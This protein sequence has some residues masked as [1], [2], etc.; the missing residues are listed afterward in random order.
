MIVSLLKRENRNR[1]AFVEPPHLASTHTSCI[2]C[3]VVW[4]VHTL[5][6]DSHRIIRPSL[7]STTTAAC[8]SSR[9]NRNQTQPKHTQFNYFEFIDAVDCNTLQCCFGES[10]DDAGEMLPTHWSQLISNVFSCTWI[11]YDIVYVQL[12]VWVVRVCVDY[13]QLWWIFTV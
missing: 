3:I 8:R 9:F 1:C 6:S 7:I 12:I 2:D 11:Y 4:T 5:C 13:N 10:N